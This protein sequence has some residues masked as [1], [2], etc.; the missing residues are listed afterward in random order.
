MISDEAV[1]KIIDSSDITEN[2]LVIEI[3]PG[4]GTLTKELLERAGK[5]ICIELDPRMVKILK[6]RFSLY[7]NFEIIYED[8]LKVDLELI[9]QN[10]KKKESIKSAKVV[11]NLP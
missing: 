10:E 4:L 11:A 9:I 1:S 7:D 3:G 5:V 8:V 6:E 2:D